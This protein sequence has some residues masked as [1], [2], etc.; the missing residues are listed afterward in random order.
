MAAVYRPREH[1]VYTG[2]QRK[3]LESSGKTVEVAC[4]NIWD[5]LLIGTR[6]GTEMLGKNWMGS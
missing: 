3:I 4:A 6:L 2:A 1:S 5:T